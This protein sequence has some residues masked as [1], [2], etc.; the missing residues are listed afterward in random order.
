MT[1][2]ARGLFIAGTDTEA[3]PPADAEDVVNNNRMRRELE[4]AQAALRLFSKDRGERAKAIAELKDQA[5]EGKLVLIEK[6]EKAET[7][8]ELKIQIAL[9]KAAVLI[10]SGDKAKL[11]YIVSLIIA[12]AAKHEAMG[13][14]VYVNIFQAER[15][16]FGSG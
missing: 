5:D 2:T 14:R 6:A 8:P 3:T 1:A 4:S 7:D 12:K 16:S 15:C 13:E 11:R 10:S 9:L